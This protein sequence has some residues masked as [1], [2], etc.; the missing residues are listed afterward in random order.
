MTCRSSNPQQ[1]R[2][3]STK[4]ELLAGRASAREPHFSGSLGSRDLP[5]GSRMI[6]GLRDISGT[7]NDA[8]REREERKIAKESAVVASYL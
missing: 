8:K 3:I 2:K 7:Q 6:P 1:I 4:N 5:R